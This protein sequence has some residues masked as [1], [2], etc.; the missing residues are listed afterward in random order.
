[1]C[2]LIDAADLGVDY[3]DHPVA[4]G[5]YDLRVLKAEVVKTKEGKDD[6]GNE[7]VIRNMIKLMIRIEGAEG[8]GAMP[9]NEQLLLPNED[10]PKDKNP[11]RMFMQRLSR[12]AK[13][14]NI[15]LK[16]LAG[17][18]EEELADRVPSLFE[19]ATGKCMLIKEEYQ[20]RESNKLNLP[21]AA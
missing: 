21:K 18:S 2:P 20:G 10:E 5:E 9:V 7:K 15:D 13:T 1:M 3:E 19:G 16:E 17:I 14:F 11:G 12:F 8:E 6:K 4:E